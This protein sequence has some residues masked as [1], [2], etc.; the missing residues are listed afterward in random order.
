M[1]ISDKLEDFKT[2][3]K[4]YYSF[5]FFPPKTD[6]GLDNL[7][8]RIDRMASLQPAYIDITWGAGGST[9][10]R[11]L[12]MSKTIQKYFGLE[13]M[14]HL[15]CTNMPVSS[16]NK[17]L[18]DVQENGLSNILALRG[19]P[20]EGN[21]EW[22]K[23]EQ[24]FKYGIDLV[25]FIRKEFGDDFFLGVAGYP[26]SHQEQSDI[27]LDV[28]YLKEKVDAGSDIVV[29]QLF[30]DV[31]KFLIFRDKCS[32]IGIHVPIIPGIMPIHNYARFIKFTQFCKISIPN[33]VTKT[34][35]SLKND[36]S[37]VINY[38]ID[39]ATSMCEK[40]IAEGVPGLHFYTLN[41]EHSVSG[42]LE[43]LGLTSTQRS[44]REL[45]WRQ[46][47]VGDRKTTEDVR[48]I[49][50]SNRPVSYLTRTE[51]WDDFPNGR[52]G[53][54]TSPTFGELN[55]YHAIRAGSK[56]DKVKARRK[57]LWGEPKSIMDITKIFVSFCE[58]KI[59]SLPWCEIPLAIE[60]GQISK[61]LVKLNESGFLTI[62]SQ[63]KVNGVPSEDPDVGWG[64]PGGRVYQKAYLEF[65]TT[66]DKLDTMLET[67]DSLDSIS[68]QATNSSGDFISNLPENC[69]N[70]VTWGVFPRQEIV[71]PT[72]VDTRS[73]LIWKDEAFSLWI[74]DWANIYDAESESYKLLNEVYNTYYLVNIVDNN[75]V[76]GDILKHILGS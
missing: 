39:Q 19:D 74:D 57:K 37:S 62:N 14:M 17:V 73:F 31:D 40:L 71:Q 69:V 12:E 35:E 75:F 43:L 15:T 16:I 3:G 9:A 67:I 68:Y 20:P 46:S 44:A 49:Y 27:D 48:P 56:S 60:S 33:S 53:D 30:Y 41:L 72:I 28:S 64:A 7:Y 70:A 58:G 11:T 25:R 66:K 4:T 52:W 45:P 65:F 38:G 36:D 2:Q 61:E 29:T 42:I 47:T 24:G 6:F 8:S 50:W 5:E 54:I 63:P 55:Q 22:E 59:K 13:V 21:V 23:H 51:T 18:V 26:D 10:D 34:I 76:D 32:T 1:K